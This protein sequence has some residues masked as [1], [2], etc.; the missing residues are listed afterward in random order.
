MGFL[1]KFETSSTRKFV[2]V[3]IKKDA[4]HQTTVNSNVY[5]SFWEAPLW[6]WRPKAKEITKE[7]MNAIVV[8]LSSHEYC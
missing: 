5:K 7:E 8:S 3:E 4:V 6:L 2:A 1:K